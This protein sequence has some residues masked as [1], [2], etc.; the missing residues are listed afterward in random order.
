MCVVP[1]E[2]DGEVFPTAFTFCVNENGNWF[3]PLTHGDPSHN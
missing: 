1:W 3:D 2:F